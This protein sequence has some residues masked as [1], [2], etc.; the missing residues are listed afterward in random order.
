MAMNLFKRRPSDLMDQD[1]RMADLR[2]KALNRTSE[3]SMRAYG[4]GTGT[5]GVP[6]GT[7]MVEEPGAATR[8]MSGVG[9]GSNVRMIGSEVVQPSDKRWDPAQVQTLMGEVSPEGRGRAAAVRTGSVAERL[10]GT[11]Q[12]SGFMVQGSQPGTVNSEPGTLFYDENHFQT[13][14]NL[15]PRFN[16]L[17]AD[18]WRRNSFEKARAARTGFANLDDY[19]Q[20]FRS[21]P[22]GKPGEFGDE[23]KAAYVEGMPPEIR[24]EWVERKNQ[25]VT[26]RQQAGATAA[27]NAQAGTKVANLAE[28]AAAEKGQEMAGKTQQMAIQKEENVRSERQLKAYETQVQQQADNGD[29]TREE[30]NLRLGNI[31]RAQGEIDAAVKQYGSLEAVPPIMSTDG[32]FYR[33]VGDLDPA[34]GAY[35][36]KPYSPWSLQEQIGARI[37]GGA[38]AGGA[39]APGPDVT[40][41]GAI[42]KDE[43]VKAFKAEKGREPTASE[44]ERAKGRYWR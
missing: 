7:V 25:I 37:G 16:K 6:V 31:K 43:F 19:D 3:D 42:S 9:T 14:S 10:L 2:A 17:Q 12:S 1:P 8:A 23:M 29:I 32:K 30:K 34:T 41:G 40:G 36:W 27:F 24:D 35:N 4:G 28:A 20:W 22:N 44:I 38:P 15:D 13:S 39:A 26:N 21:I 11:V 33:N 18:Y 5:S